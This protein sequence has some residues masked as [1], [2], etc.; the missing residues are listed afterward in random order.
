MHFSTFSTHWFAAAS[1]GQSTRPDRT[2]ISFG[3]SLG[4]HRVMTCITAALIA[5]YI[6]SSQD[7]LAENIER[8]P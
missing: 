8:C 6:A 5:N 7:M 1:A 4:V 2:H 3:E